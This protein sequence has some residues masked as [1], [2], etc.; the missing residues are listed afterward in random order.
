VPQHLPALKEL[1]APVIASPME[2]PIAKAE[3]EYILK[4]KEAPLEN[5]FA[6]EIQNEI[7]TIQNT[8]PEPAELPRRIC[9]LLVD[10]R[11][12]LQ[13][14]GAVLD[15]RVLLLL[16]VVLPA[17]RVAVW[18][19]AFASESRTKRVKLHLRHAQASSE[20]M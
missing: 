16:Q 18:A 9:L 2:D 1:D 19:Q 12:P 13:G 14:I 6:P 15:Q 3:L 5:L 20:G 11:Q 10:V 17:L 8:E 4:L 7:H